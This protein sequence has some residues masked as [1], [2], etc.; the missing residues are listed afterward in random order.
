MTV[1]LGGGEKQ[2]LHAVV[3]PY[4]A[5]GHS[6]PLLHFAKRL[7]AMGVTVTF[8]NVFNHLSKEV[9]RS[10][11]GL[12]LT[13]LRVVPLGDCSLEPGG[14][15]LPYIRHT[16]SLEPEAEL[17]LES[18]FAQDPESPPACIISDMFLGWTQ[19]INPPPT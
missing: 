19:V 14:G 18:L 6:I 3:L 8:V 17:L 16:E 10:L 12:D 2:R 1:T 11:E 13:A 15:S 9:F 7:H 4:P 5:R